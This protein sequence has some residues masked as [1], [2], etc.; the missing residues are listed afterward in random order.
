[1]MVEGS[2]SFAGTRQ[3]V[4]NLLLDE[5]VIGLAM[6]GCRQ[7]T[8]VSP[9]RYEGLMQVGVGPI[10]AAEFSV[11]IDL[12]DLNPPRSYV[13]EVDGQGRFGFTRGTARVSLD[14]EGRGT[15]MNYEADLMIGGKIASV[16]QRLLDTVS[17]VMTRR[18]LDTLAA[19][20]ER[21]LAADSSGTASGGAS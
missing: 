7:L 14:E 8:R 12:R 5:T 1:M 19:E 17:R 20:M 11:S 13:M 16:G 2:Y 10:T 18:G 3:A 15:V 9:V 4:W 21:R 6:P